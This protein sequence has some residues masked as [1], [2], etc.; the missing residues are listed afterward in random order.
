[1]A[2]SARELGWDADLWTLRR[3]IG[4]VRWFWV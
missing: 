2:L 1:M 3:L 4:A